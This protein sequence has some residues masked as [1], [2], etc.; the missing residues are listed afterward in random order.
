[1]LFSLVAR[2]LI[3]PGK[4]VVICICEQRR[5]WLR[6]SL[7]TLHIRSWADTPSHRR[8][9]GLGAFSHQPAC[10][11]LKLDP[12]EAWLQR[13]GGTRLPSEALDRADLSFRP[14]FLQQIL[15]LQVILITSLSLSF[16]SWIFLS[17][18]SSALP[19][20]LLLLLLFLSLFSSLRRR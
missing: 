5:H 2:R 14:P 11:Y 17:S 15:S 16:L 6:H 18:L 1:M 10:Y 20:C 3:Q 9:D 19:A 4:R 13:L 12:H 8:D 7:H